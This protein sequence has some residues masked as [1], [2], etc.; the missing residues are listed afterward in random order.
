MKKIIILLTTLLFVST[1]AQDA[2]NPNVELPDFVITGKDVILMRRV[3]KIPADFVSTISEEYLKPVIKPEELEVTNISNP[4]ARDNSVFDSVKFY[5][6]IISLESGRYKLPAGEVNYMFPFERG[7]LHGIITG[8]NQL[9]YVNNSDRKNIF[10]ALKF[11]YS[12]SANGEFLPGTKFTIG[13]KHDKN[14]YKF[15]GS[16]TPEFERTLNIGTA[17][18]GLQNLYMSQ[19]IFDLEFA[20]DFTYLD[21][22]GFTESLFY[23]NAFG[24]YNTK[25]F[26]IN[27][28]AN[29]Q[30]QLLK[31]D[32][33][34]DV[35]SS[36]VF[37]RPSVSLELF[38]K[39]NA[40]IGFSFSK[41]GENSFNSLFAS[42]GFKFAEHLVL[43]AEYSPHSEFITAGKLLRA[44]YYFNQQNIENIF[45][46]RKNN[47]KASIKY[48]YG[49]YYQINGGIEYHKAENLP[50]YVNTDQSGFFEVSAT[51][52]TNLN[53][54]LDLIYHMGPY[55]IF[56]ARF[57]YF[58]IEDDENRKIPYYPYLKGSLSYGYDFSNG[59]QADILLWYLSDRFADLDNEIELKSFFNLNFKLTYKI[60]EQFL[61]KLHLEN[62]LNTKRFIWQGYQEKPFD[63][64][65]G[66]S[67]LFD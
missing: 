49:K 13:G 16:T 23:S 65:L 4:V 64:A 30:N 36:Y 31:T 47:L 43:L 5:R 37:V 55:G 48:E 25:N 44:N 3:E 8:F 56:Y 15:F 2:K 26:G 28:K 27:L 14:S 46:K 38:D 67:F 53:L 52:A 51:N 9:E 33:L 32:S 35:S 1:F 17:K 41:S 61:I 66:F 58:E 62:V 11:N 59:L 54:F 63:V 19:F 12:L 57:D 22:D 60:K 18:A 21:N 10:G 39:L 34:A 20:G 42:L 7:M 45:L 40:D 29:T 6:G 24:R 50:Y